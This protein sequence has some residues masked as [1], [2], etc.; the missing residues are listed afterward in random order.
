MSAVA[1][2]RKLNRVVTSA[3]LSYKGA[4]QA[5]GLKITKYNRRMMTAALQAIVSTRFEQGWSGHHGLRHRHVVPST[6]GAV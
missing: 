1:A 2:G 3:Q 4:H 6:F 5:K